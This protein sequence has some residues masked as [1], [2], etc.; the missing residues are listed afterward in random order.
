MGF[1]NKIKGAFGGGND[2]DDYSGAPFAMEGAD[3]EDEEVEPELAFLPEEG[4]VD[5]AT[6]EQLLSGEREIDL[7]GGYA[8]AEPEPSGLTEAQVEMADVQSRMMDAEE[9]VAKDEEEAEER[10]E[11]E[12]EWEL[13][14]REN[15]NYT[16]DY[17]IVPLEESPDVPEEFDDEIWLKDVSQISKEFSE[18]SDEEQA[19]MWEL[20]KRE[21]IPG[22]TP[23]YSAAPAE[24]EQQLGFRETP[25]IETSVSEEVEQQ[26]VYPKSEQP[27]IPV[28]GQLE[29][30]P[31]EGTPMEARF[32]VARG[33]EE[34][35]AEARRISDEPALRA[36]AMRI[37]L[38][39]K[40]LSSEELRLQQNYPE[41]LE[42]ELKSIQE[43]RE[44]KIRIEAEKT[45]PWEELS[46]EQ[47][48]LLAEGQLEWMRD[49]VEETPPAVTEVEG[50]ESEEDREARI[51]AEAGILGKV[52]TELIDD[53]YSSGKWVRKQLETKLR[54]ITP[55]EYQK[56]IDEKK[57]REAQKKVSE[58]EIKQHEREAKQRSYEAGLKEIQS[59]AEREN[60][61][62]YGSPEEKAQVEADE[63]RE[64][65]EEEQSK[66][67]ARKEISFGKQQL[68]EME[69][70]IKKRDVKKTKEQIT[71]EFN[72]EIGRILEAAYEHPKRGQ[73]IIQEAKLYMKMA[74]LKLG[75][76]PELL[77]KTKKLR[78]RAEKTYREIAGQIVRGIGRGT[79]EFVAYSEKPIRG[80]SK[81]TRRGGEGYGRQW[82]EQGAK[83]ILGPSP[84][85][86]E[87]AQTRKPLGPA[88]PG[89]P[90]LKE[91]PVSTAGI[92]E[93]A[94]LATG[95]SMVDTRR[96][97]E[98]GPAEP[99]GVLGTPAGGAKYMIGGPKQKM[100]V[101]AKSLDIFDFIGSRSTPLD[102]G[103]Q[104][105][106]SG[107]GASVVGPG[108][109]VSGTPRIKKMDVR[110]LV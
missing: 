20:R 58:E 95:R 10:D 71:L 31:E 106:P 17:S 72:D 79:K 18:L 55:L 70:D 92:R 16:P 96:G 86:P 27:S 77:A 47:K 35:E 25:G 7:L 63:R 64:K 91:S 62:K 103:V 90:R 48:R 85:I 109:Y 102:T 23:D 87:G 36:L 94:A 49:I 52:K 82:Q 9:Q 93:Q 14:K 61:K 34:A 88:G 89:E 78:K 68:K 104:A 60:I 26:V 37:S 57:M 80:L 67:Q 73:P 51:L 4:E 12:R 2:D 76:T 56:R 11:L 108:I 54:G 84:I 59:K 83:R 6:I 66:Q 101:E 53:P 19:L 50:Y 46:S 29:G 74:E 81:A 98:M 45:Y 8:A 99:I 30:D 44:A 38:G 3:E 15:P 100:D 32:G 28:H 43:V 65:L 33:S 42:A 13:R 107:A 41:D 1:M 97:I 105:L 22:Y 5:T 24:G 21:R 69:A 40:D 75:V 39:Y 110:E